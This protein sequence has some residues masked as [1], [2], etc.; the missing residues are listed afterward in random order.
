VTRPLD[1]ADRDLIELGIRRDDF[2][3]CSSSVLSLLDAYDAATA[4]L[5]RV[6]AEVARAP[7]SVG[8]EDW[9]W[10]AYDQAACAHVVIALRAALAGQPEAPVPHTCW[11]DPDPSFCA[12]CKRQAEAPDYSAHDEY[13]DSMGSPMAESK[14]CQPEAPKGNEALDTILQYCLVCTEKERRNV[15][16][17]MAM[18]GLRIVTQEAPKGQKAAPLSAREH[19]RRRGSLDGADAQALEGALSQ[20]ERDLA[21]AKA[22]A[23]SREGALRATCDALDAANAR[24]AESDRRARTYEVANGKLI[25]E[26]N[27]ANEPRRRSGN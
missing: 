12:A 26:R 4:T 23:H 14:A 6:R 7:A 27:A 18:A 13:C 20:A 24:I 15:F 1:G 9:D 10:D 2:G 22:E 3:V 8:T 5:E 21:A 16:G 11:R 17:A 19:A 25:E